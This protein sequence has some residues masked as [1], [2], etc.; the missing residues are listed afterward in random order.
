MLRKPIIAM[1]CSIECTE[2][3]QESKLPK[4]YYEA[5]LQAGGVP[6][7][8]PF[9]TNREVISSYIDTCDGFLFTGGKDINPLYIEYKNHCYNSYP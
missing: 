2:D 8:L 7:I 4:S 1:L 5:I 6:I 9:T 3:M